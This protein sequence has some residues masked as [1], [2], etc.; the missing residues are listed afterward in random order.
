MTEKET[1]PR[2]VPTPPK[3]QVEERSITTSLI[4]DMAIVAGPAIGAYVTHKLAKND[5]PKNAPPP[6]EP[7]K[8]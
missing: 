7:P 4:T 5:A 3:P 1:R 8:N 6:Q 2:P